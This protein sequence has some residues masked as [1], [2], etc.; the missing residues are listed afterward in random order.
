[1]I[2]RLTK[3]ASEKQEIKLSSDSIANIAK[4]RYC[5]WFVDIFNGGDRKKYF[6]ITN[7]FSLFSIVLPSKGLNSAESFLETVKRELQEY[8]A[9]RNLNE[10]FLE[11]I[12]PNLGKIE[13]AKKNSRSVQGCMNGMKEHIPYGIKR[14]GDLAKQKNR[15][16]LNDDLNRYPTNCANTGAGDYTFAEKLITSDLMK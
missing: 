11:F 9:Y 5:D 1:M 16:L 10:I 12:A 4:N 13:F 3:S 14:Y 7:A 8:F 2:L 15:F 6:L